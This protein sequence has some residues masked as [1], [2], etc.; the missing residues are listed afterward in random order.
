LQDHF[1]RAEVCHT[2]ISYSIKAI[3]RCGKRGYCGWKKRLLQRSDG[4]IMEIH[5][6]G[7]PGLENEPPSVLLFALAAAAAIF[8]AVHCTSQKWAQR[9]LRYFTRSLGFMMG[10]FFLEMIPEIRRRR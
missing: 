3:R 1:I 6:A 8:W 2:R 4:D 10:T 7:K 9:S 5:T